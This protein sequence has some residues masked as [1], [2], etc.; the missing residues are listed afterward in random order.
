VVGHFAI[1][2]ET[3]EPA[4]RQVQVDFLAQPPFRADAKAVADDQHPDQQLRIDR[5]AAFLAIEW[6]QPPPQL[7]EFHEPVDRA[8]QVPLGHMT[9][10]RKLA[11]QSVL[12]DAAFPHH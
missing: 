2:A 3:A 10:E 11:K 9:V 12:P 6:R 4:V 1:Q 7:A 5:W 8:Q